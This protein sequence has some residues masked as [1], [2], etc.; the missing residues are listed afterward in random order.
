MDV[1]KFMCDKLIAEGEMMGYSLVKDLIRA[2]IAQD[3]KERQPWCP[4]CGRE[5]GEPDPLADRLERMADRLFKLG[6]MEKSPCF[7]CG[8]NGP[9]YYQPSV[10]PCA[11]RHHAA[12]EEAEK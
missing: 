5:L 12:L 1:E 10:H 9:N 4:I 6:E 11:A 3:R 7:Y 2:A 8:Y